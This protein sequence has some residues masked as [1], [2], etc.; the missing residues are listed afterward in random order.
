MSQPAITPF[1]AEGSIPKDSPTADGPHRVYVAATNHCNRSCPWCSTCSSPEGNTWLGMEEYRKSFPQE[2]E[3][4][5]HLEGGEPTLHPRFFDFVDIASAEQRCRRVIICT[6]GTTLPRDRDRLTRWVLRLGPK[7]GIKLSINH[8]LLEHDPGLIELARRLG[9]IMKESGRTLVIN[10]RLRKGVAND[11]AAVRNA[12]RE[13]G[14]LPW[15][16]IFFLRRYG[17]AENEKDWDLP[18]LVGHNFRMVNPDG[19]IFGS[20]LAERSEAMRNLP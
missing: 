2:G 14:L 16:N 12:I 9:A 3:F 6:N 1:D 10:A 17:F 5:I 18:I 8:H 20:A 13:G 7:G 15:A 4:E 11:D 19:V